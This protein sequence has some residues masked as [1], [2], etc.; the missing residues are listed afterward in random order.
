MIDPEF[1]IS[2]ATSKYTSPFD[3]VMAIEAAGI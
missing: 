1:I 2:S 3:P